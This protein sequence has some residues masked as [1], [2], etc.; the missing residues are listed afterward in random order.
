MINR[1]KFAGLSTEEKRILGE[2]IFYPEWEVEDNPNEALI[3]ALTRCWDG[4]RVFIDNQG[5]TKEG[6][7]PNTFIDI[8]KKL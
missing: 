3:R 4:S 8:V 1:E 7:D 2:L 6:G 5:N